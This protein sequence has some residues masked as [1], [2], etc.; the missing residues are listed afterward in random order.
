MHVASRSK[1]VGARG[2]LEAWGDRANVQ[3]LWGILQAHD[4]VIVSRYSLS[5]KN[6]MTVIVRACAAFGL[7]VFEAGTEVTCLWPKGAAEIRFDVF[8][9]GQVRERRI[10]GAGPVA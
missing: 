8:A 9:A 6:R 7:A 3:T 2:C 5:P 10:I 1:G 4:K